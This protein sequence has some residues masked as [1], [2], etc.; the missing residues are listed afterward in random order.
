MH[1]HIY[2]D[3]F[4][5]NSSFIVVFS[6]DLT[7]CKIFISIWLVK[8]I[9]NQFIFFFDAIRKKKPPLSYLKVYLNKQWVNKKK[10]YNKFVFYM[11]IISNN[12]NNILHAP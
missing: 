1:W 5:E 6:I 9:V 3:W 2:Y 10:P 8:F 7:E 11:H 12:Y 4:N